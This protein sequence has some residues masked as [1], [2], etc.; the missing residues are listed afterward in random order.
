[1]VKLRL[2][3]IGKRKQP[4]YRIVAAHISVARNGRALAE[5]GLYDPMH[6][7]VKIDEERAIEWLNK[8]AQMTET[9]ADLF[10]S[11]GVLAR[12]KG[13]EGRVRDDALSGDKPKSRRKKAAAEPVEQEEAAP[14]KQ[15]AAEPEAAAPDEQVAAESAESAEQEEK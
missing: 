4:Y 2:K 14:V 9:V 8:G 1:M 13:A 15:V 5:V 10:H 3:R 6:A 11:Q 7:S 12:W